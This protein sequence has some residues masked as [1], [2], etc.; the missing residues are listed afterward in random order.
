MGILSALAMTAGLLAATTT[1]ASAAPSACNYDHVSNVCLT[2]EYAGPGKWDVH[3]GFARYMPKSQADEILACPGG[4]TF[5]AVMWGDDGG[6][7]YDDNLGDIPLVAGYPRSDSNPDGL[8][9]EFFR[10]GMNLN[11]DS[12]TDEVYAEVTY[13]DC[14]N[15]QRF[16]YRTGTIHGML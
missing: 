3:V 8:F 10:P 14:H 6:P 2:I 13:F 5:F 11:E 1:P 12:G 16:T 7:S 9:A 4:G 15:G